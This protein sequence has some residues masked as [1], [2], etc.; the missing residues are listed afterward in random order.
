[1]VGHTLW[2]VFLGHEEM[3]KGQRIVGALLTSGGFC[4]EGKEGNGCP[5][6]VLTGSGSGEEQLP[7]GGQ[8]YGE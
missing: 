3:G 4:L 1:M 8:V 2:S 7:A 6:L 5:L